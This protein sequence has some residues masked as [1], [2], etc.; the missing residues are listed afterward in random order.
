MWCVGKSGVGERALCGGR[1]G[2]LSCIWKD[3]GME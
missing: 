2:G 1:N 3:A